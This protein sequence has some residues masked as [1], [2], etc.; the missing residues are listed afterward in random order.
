MVCRCFIFIFI[1]F[2]VIFCIPCL[3]L[4]GIP[5]KEGCFEGLQSEPAPSVPS[6]TISYNKILAFFFFLLFFLNANV[7]DCHR[8]EGMTKDVGVGG[9]TSSFNSKVMCIV[10]G[11]PHL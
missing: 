6:S 7:N 2:L 8:T 3:Y 10:H 11:F 1:F 5:G 9:W 4:A